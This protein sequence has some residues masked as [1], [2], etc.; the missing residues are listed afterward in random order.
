MFLKIQEVNTVGMLTFKLMSGGYFLGLYSAFFFF[1]C[2]KQNKNNVFS[3][4]N[5][6]GQ[7]S[8]GDGSL[9]RQPARFEKAGRF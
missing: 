9:S 7:T 5:G 8:R 4:W 2:R 1:P 3:P 6:D